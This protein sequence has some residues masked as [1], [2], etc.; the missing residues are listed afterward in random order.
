[1]KHGTP[2]CVTSKLPESLLPKGKLELTE[3]PKYSINS[4]N[5]KKMA[6][7][8]G[9]NELPAVSYGFIGKYSRSTL[10]GK[11]EVLT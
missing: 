2:H 1:M 3:N 4:S 9:S 8:E 10:C 11:L 6:S 7:Q 5:F